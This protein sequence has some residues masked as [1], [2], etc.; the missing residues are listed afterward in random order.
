MDAGLHSTDGLI[1][2]PGFRFAAA[3][4]GR[5]PNLRDRPA[6]YRGHRV[7]GGFDKLEQ[8][9]VLGGNHARIRQG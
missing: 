4:I 5:L 2:Q 9:Q 7:F 8:G 1:Y 3:Q 6:I